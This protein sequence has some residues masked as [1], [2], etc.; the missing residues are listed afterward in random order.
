LFGFPSAFPAIPVRGDVTRKITSVRFNV[1]E[2]TGEHFCCKCTTETSA[3]VETQSE[4]AKMQQHGTQVKDVTMTLNQAEAH[5]RSNPLLD[6]N[7]CL[8]CP[9][10]NPT[11]QSKGITCSISCESNPMVAVEHHN[12]HCSMW[13]NKQSQS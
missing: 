3:G 8:A 2:F 7:N 4:C 10:P 6:E 13:A 12:E 1:Q 9:R 5:A 11:L